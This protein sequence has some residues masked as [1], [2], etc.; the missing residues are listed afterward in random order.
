MAGVPRTARVGSRL[1]GRYLLQGAAAGGGGSATSLEDRRRGEREDTAGDRRS[2]PRPHPGGATA[3]DGP[4]AVPTGGPAR[5]PAAAAGGRQVPAPSG[6]PGAAGRSEGATPSPPITWRGHDDLL[7]RTVSLRVLPADS[8]LVARVL[9]AAS[10]ASS[11]DDPRFLA[12]LD[13]AETEGLVY[14]VSE[15]VEGRTLTELLDDGPLSTVEAARIAGEVGRGL[16]AAHRAGLAHGHLTTDAVV[17]TDGGRVKI[18]GLA[19]DGA[20]RGDEPGLDDDTRTSDLRAAGALLYA[21]LTRRWP[22]LPGVPPSAALAPAPVSDGQSCAPRQV[23]AAIPT[24]LDDVTCRALGLPHRH[25]GPAI[26]TAHEFA[27]ALLGPASAVDVTGPVQAVTGDDEGVRLLAA[28]ASTGRVGRVAGL[29]A[30]AVLVVGLA[31]LL[32]QLLVNDRDDR[33]SGRVTT[34]LTPQPEPSPSV[35]GSAAPTPV[36]QH[37]DLTPVRALSFDP[38]GN[39]EE[40]EDRVK[41]AWDDDL[42]TYWPT[43]TYFHAP[44][45]GAKDGVGLI[46]DLGRPQALAS[47]SLNLPKAGSSVEVRTT[48][49]TGGVPPAALSGWTRDIRASGVGTARTLK[50]PAPVTSR[51]VLVW[52]TAL[53]TS[54]DKTWSGG[55]SDVR[56]RS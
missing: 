24:Y 11:L 5:G 55:I 9:S 53:P 42:S 14:V 44:W 41:R 29:V 17:L 8:V 15:W 35:S 32:G 16:A 26:T 54:G 12:V 25:G 34:A 43:K 22:E 27:D 10:R 38:Q 3:H 13:A 45:G 6:P 18:V 39:K 51:Y 50:L 31:L 30:A 28:P 40:N 2:D 36:V 23:R 46:L 7:D 21:G 4:N 47:V 56:I 37:A 49:T 48:S 20:L 33:D 19:I 52:L 1:A